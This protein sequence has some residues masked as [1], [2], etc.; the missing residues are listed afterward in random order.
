[1]RNLAIYPITPEER[2]KAFDEAVAC[3]KH[4]GMQMFGGEII[5][6]ITGSA[7]ESIRRDLENS[8]ALFGEFGTFQSVGSIEPADER[9]E[10]GGQS[11]V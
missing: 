2:L 9:S 11:D 7:L 3:W 5:G 6:D 10:A 1:M 4:A 8:V